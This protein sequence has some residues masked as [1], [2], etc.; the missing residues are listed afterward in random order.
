MRAVFQACMVDD[1]EQ[2]NEYAAEAGNDMEEGDERGA[3][4]QGARDVEG[5]ERKVNPCPV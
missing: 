1:D 5:I 2:E 4:G 3:V